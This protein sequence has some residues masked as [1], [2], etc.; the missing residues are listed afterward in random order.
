MPIQALVSGYL[1][2]SIIRRHVSTEDVYNAHH[3]VRVT[4]IHSAALIEDNML[5]SSVVTTY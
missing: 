1:D 4:Y 2:E 3:E 5:D